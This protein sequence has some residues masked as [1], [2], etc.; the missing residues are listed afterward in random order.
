MCE[1]SSHL[2]KN[3]AE[4]EHNSSCFVCTSHSNRPDNAAVALQW[5]EYVTLR[6]D[7]SSVHQHSGTR[8]VDYFEPDERWEKD[9]KVLHS[10]RVH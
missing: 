1:L 10:A 6:H 9:S 5:H 2:E 8:T 3:V 4:S 7:R